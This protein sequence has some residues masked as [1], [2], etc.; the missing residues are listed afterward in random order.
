MA[1]AWRRDLNTALVTRRSTQQDPASS[2][3]R[4]KRRLRAFDRPV[5]EAFTMGR[6]RQRHIDY[7]SDIRRLDRWLQSWMYICMERNATAVTQ[8]TCRMYRRGDSP[9][10]R[11][12]K[13]LAPKQARYLKAAHT[14]EFTGDTVEAED[15]PFMQVLERPNP[16][17][18]KAGLYLLTITYLQG[19]GQ[20]YWHKHFT[21]DGELTELWPLPSQYVTPMYGEGTIIDEY[22]LRMGR[23]VRIFPREEIVH[24]RI[25]SPLDTISGFGNLRGILETAELDIRM[26]EYERALMDNMAVPDI[27]ISAKG[28]TVPQQLE[29][30]QDEW[31]QKFQGHTR[32]GKAAAV[33]FPIDVTQL[34]FKN[35]DLEFD[36][37]SIRVRDKI[38]AG[39]GVPIP[40]L[41]STSTTFSNMDI[42]VQLWMRNKIQP[43]LVLLA[44]TINHDIM[45]HYS[46]TAED[47]GE[48]KVPERTP[49]FI[50][51]DNPVPEDLTS[52]NDRDVADLGAGVVIIN[53]VRH[54][55]NMEPVPWGDEPWMQ[56][57]LETPTMAED[58]LRHTQEME[59]MQFERDGDAAAAAAEAGP[60]TTFA[61]LTTGLDLLSKIGDLDGVNLIRQQMAGLLGGMLVPVAELAPSPDGAIVDP[62]DVAERPQ[63]QESQDDGQD[64]PQEQEGQEGRGGNGDGV[65]AGASGGD[66]SGD[67]PGK[68]APTGEPESQASGKRDSDQDGGGGDGSTDNGDVREDVFDRAAWD[69]RVRE[70]Y[71]KVARLLMDPE[72]RDKS[73]EYVLS[74]LFA[75]FESEVMAK[76]ATITAK[77]AK[78]KLPESVGKLVAALFSRAK[79]ITRFVEAAMPSLRF[80]F[81]QGAELG[82]QDLTRAGVDMVE[83][84]P[85]DR[86]EKHVQRLAESFASSVVDMTGEQL[87]AA[88]LPGIHE[89][90]NM[91]ELA[92]RVA[93][94]YGQKKDTHAELIARTE[95]NTAMNAGASE[96]FVESGIKKHEWMASS[97]ACEFCLVLDGNVVKIGEPFAKL[98]STITGKRGGTYKVRY[99][100]IKHP[101]LHPHCTCTIV[102]VIE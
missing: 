57:G 3:G 80:A 79:W 36:K 95:V 10:P 73:L 68:R 74:G 4:S 83:S 30:L 81:R 58:R 65:S 8:Q 72:H 43:L 93:E 22:E 69:K 99:R 48:D 24:F 9:G 67:K 38:A 16:I 89:G 78:A 7:R 61:E 84:L 98:G 85:P 26:L 29:A 71:A 88:L 91:E 40:I 50:A 47:V 14:G 31:E 52:Q 11:S 35:R 42:G 63:T 49:W 102:P 90:E 97:S 59:R 86:I 53:E 17:L 51:F 27:L 13:A 87:A 5:V 33:P 39:F 15:H 56:P 60:S 28:D 1:P 6:I 55:R 20:G 64:G 76:L 21:P 2:N 45:P 100:A 82:V 54:E 70:A 34:S 96:T 77:S 92:K 32:R 23:A 94:V 18:D 37:G 25:P 12:V 66:G 44:S 62:E 19:T 41:T 75:E 46:P 101:T